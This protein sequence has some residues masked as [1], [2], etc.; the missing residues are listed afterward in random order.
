MV[1]LLAGVTLIW[2]FSTVGSFVSLHVVFL[3][4]AHVALVTA[5]RLLSCP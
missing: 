1:Y 2:L 4:E 3:D 5:K